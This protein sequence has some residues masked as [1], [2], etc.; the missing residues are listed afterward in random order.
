MEPTNSSL[1]HNRSLAFFNELGDFSQRFDESI[2][3]WSTALLNDDGIIHP[4]KPNSVKNF[5][6][7][8]LE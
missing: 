8:I 2:H 3:L 5:A 1:P 6:D 7:V 4:I